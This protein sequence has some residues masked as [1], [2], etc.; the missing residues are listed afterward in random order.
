MKWMRKNLSER[1]NKIEKS[2]KG[3][4]EHLQ[5]WENWVDEA[6]LRVSDMQVCSSRADW[7]L[8]YMIDKTT[9]FRSA[10]WRQLRK[11]KEVQPIHLWSKGMDWGRWEYDQI[12]SKTT[13]SGS[14]TTRRRRTA[15]V[16]RAHT[17]LLHQNPHCG[18]IPS[19]S[20]KATDPVQRLEH[21]RLEVWKSYHIGLW[22]LYRVGAMSMEILNISWKECW[23]K[24]RSSYPAESYPGWRKDLQ[25]CMWSR[26]TTEAS[27]NHHQAVRTLGHITYY[28][29]TQPYRCLRKRLIGNDIDAQAYF[30]YYA[31]VSWAAGKQAGHK[32]YCY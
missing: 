17:G 18:E 29:D 16:L 19:L 12:H 22:L 15:S 20:N 10:L 21:K 6:E 9:P 1:L 5:A 13:W 30:G 8:A 4:N 32:Q 3:V 28:K 7:L 14:Q 31:V 25:L 23:M 2:L 11:S 24:F 26:R 27:R